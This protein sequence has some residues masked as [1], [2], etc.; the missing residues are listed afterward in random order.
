LGNRDKTN[1]DHRQRGHAPGVFPPIQDVDCDPFDKQRQD[2]SRRYHY[3]VATNT[4]AKKP[5][6]LSQRKPADRH[7]QQHH[8]SIPQARDETVP[9]DYGAITFQAGI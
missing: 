1:V 9:Q 6:R 2:K 8:N 3:Q 5:I 7:D 4:W